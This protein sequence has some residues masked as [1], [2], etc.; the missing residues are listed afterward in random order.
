MK[1]ILL[2]FLF[3]TTVFSQ[4]KLSVNPGIKLGV[5]FGEKVQFIFGTELSFVF[6]NFGSDDNERYGITLDYDSVDD[7]AFPQKL[8]S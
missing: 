1:T 6:Y 5:A 4:T 7:Y 3:S 2:F 8:D